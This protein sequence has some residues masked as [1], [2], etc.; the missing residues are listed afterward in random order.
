[1]SGVKLNQL[2]MSKYEDKRARLLS[3]LINRPFKFGNQSTYASLEAYFASILYP[4][5]DPR[6]EL[7]RYACY[8]QAQKYVREA[9]K[10]TVYAA[11]GCPFRYG[12]SAH[13]MYCA[14]AVQESI[15]Q[16]SDREQALR[17]TG[18]M[19]LVYDPGFPEP[20]DAF[21]TRAE[22]AECLMELRA[23][24][25][26]TTTITMVVAMD[27]DGAIGKDA[28]IPWEMKADMKHFRSVTL[29][30][31]VIMGRKTWDSIGAR[32]L[33]GRTNVIL[34]RQLDYRAEGAF[35]IHDPKDWELTDNCYII[36]GA[37]IYKLYE[38]QGTRVQWFVSRIPGKHPGCDTFYQVPIDA[39][40]VDS[41]LLPSGLEVDIYM[42]EKSPQSA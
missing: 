33:G 34:T 25:L 20:D 6:N 38:N 21:F 19:E 4:P 29:G 17:D 5:S 26:K 42:K 16:N 12:D 37:E 9:P 28:S 14:R 1:M 8:G 40:H 18:D 27:G 10:D 24:L 3:K 39:R 41:D 32:P 2:N 36:G 15:L 11:Y 7:A 31:T 23:K 22:F 30:K 35:V 13:K